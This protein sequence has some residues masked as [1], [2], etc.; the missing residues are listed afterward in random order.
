MIWKIVKKAGIGLGIFIGV[1]A[2]YLLVAWSCSHISVSAEKDEQKGEIAIY[3]LTNGVHSDIVMPVRTG[4]VDWSHFF[5]FE[6]IISQ[7]TTYRFVAVGWGDKGFYMEIPEWSDLTLGI[8]LKA[9]LGLGTSA[10]H[11]TYY[12]RMTEDD[13]CV[14]ILITESQYQRLIQYI[15][16]SRQTDVNGNSIYIETDAQYGVTDSFYEAKRRYSIFY[17]CN[18]WTNNAL[19][20]AGQKG[21]LWTLD[22]QGIFRHYR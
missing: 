1:L 12:K 5:P 9:G 14:K 17:T 13:D 22:C 7:D 3:L 20:N 4:L 21:A 6:N 15:Q 10:L 19:K 16:D 18:T 2:L 8:A 11:V